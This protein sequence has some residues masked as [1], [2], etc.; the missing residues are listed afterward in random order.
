MGRGLKNRNFTKRK[1]AF[2]ANVYTSIPAKFQDPSSVRLGVIART[3]KSEDL[4]K[5]WG[6]ANRWMN[7]LWVECW[8]STTLYFVLGRSLG[9]GKRNSVKSLG[10]SKL[11]GE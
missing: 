1:Y 4:S 5:H 3:E 6:Y 2:L 8:N 11:W 10:L 9:L 7:T